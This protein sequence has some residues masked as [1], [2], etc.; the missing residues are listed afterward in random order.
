MMFLRAV[1]SM[2]RHL[3]VVEPGT[4]LGR[5]SRRSGEEWLPGERR[6]RVS[7]ALPGVIGHEGKGS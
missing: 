4:I 1:F 3:Q 2:D 5:C 7:A 6:G